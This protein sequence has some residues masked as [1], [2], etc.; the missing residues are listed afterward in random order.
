ME[1]ALV[2]FGILIAFLLIIVNILNNELGELRQE[3]TQKL[4]VLTKAHYKPLV[5]EYVKLKGIQHYSQRSD[6]LIYGECAFSFRMSPFVIYYSELEQKI[7]ELK[8]DLERNCCKTVAPQKK[9]R[10]KK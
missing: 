10:A 6:A 8:K 7:A 2:I 4:N 3:H 1:L 5:E 9:A